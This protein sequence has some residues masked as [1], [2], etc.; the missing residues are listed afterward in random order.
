MGIRLTVNGREVEV[1]EGST[2]LQACEA[3]GYEIPRFCYHERLSIA[4]LC[5]MCLVEM[6]RSPKPIASCAMPA[7][8][9]MVIRTD[10]AAVR[11]SRE[12]V[13][14]IQLINH[15]LDCPICDQGGEC[16]LQD[17]SLGY[18]R[19]YSRFTDEKRAVSEQYMGPLIQ[20][21]MTRCIH[22]TRCVRFAAEVAGVEDLG[23]INR[24]EGAEITTMG[25]P[26]DSELSGCLVDVCPVGALTSAPY[27]FSARP[28]E[29]SH[30][31][32]I[33]VTDGVAS[34]IRVDSRAR[35]VLRVLPR[36][37]EDINEEW[38]HDKARHSIDGLRVQRLDR[39]YLRGK[40]GRLEEVSWGVALGT[41]AEKLRLTAPERV[42]AIAG[43]LVDCEAMY[44]LRLLLR[45][46]GVG[47]M[48]CR[49]EGGEL[50]LPRVGWLFNAG[51]SGIEDADAVLLV[52]TNPRDEGVL[53]NARLRKRFLRGDFRI[54]S[55]GA[56]ADLTYGVEHLG[57]SAQTLEAL[58]GG[59]HPFAEVLG[60][61]E[62]GM[63]IVGSSVLAR[64]DGGALMHLLHRLCESTGVAGVSGSGDWNGF[65]VLQR[66][67]SRVGG[68]LLDFVPS[69]GGKGTEEILS[70]SSRGEMDVVWLL[71]ADEIDMG[72][73]GESFVVYQGHHGEAGAGRADLIL[74]SAAW[75]EKDG[76]YVNTEG[77]VQL[78][79]RAIF[80]PGESREDWKIV[81]ALSGELGEAL[82]FDSLQELRARMFADCAALAEL[83]KPLVAEWEPFGEAGS[84]S[85]EP[86]RHVVSDFY[87][88]D[89]ISRLSR[90]MA[91]CSAVRRRVRTEGGAVGGALG[92]TLGGAF[93]E[94]A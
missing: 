9:G 48:D 46:L 77:R 41:L 16:D 71:G 30:T 72:R 14:E 63:V 10:T 12:G 78:A 94:A 57:D 51:I 7:G 24:G 83:D 36:V 92:G 33:D 18:G 6:E 37:H 17:Q 13:M 1:A 42:G 3:A 39:P 35:E 84:V 89:V 81:R 38:I 11:A 2:V 21:F 23:V 79:R 87:R 44:S 61:A 31:E 73:L 28:W 58:A 67:A 32:S 65:C 69:A 29:L 54:A 40:D 76:L 82:P 45:G 15:P 64:G 62:R 49:Q 50:L 4:G 59:G 5:R 19:S 53:V 55:L 52:G 90:T 56:V 60:R 70:A 68:L 85:G 66:S 86:L 22:C 8:E 80:P 74:P 27:S 75:P 43:D 91:E 88:T 25:R 47:S 20:T 26:L 34:N 93:G